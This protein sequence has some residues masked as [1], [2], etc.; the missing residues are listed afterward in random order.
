MEFVIHTH[1]SQITVREKL[2]SGTAT[3]FDETLYKYVK[4][5]MENSSDG[6]GLPDFKKIRNGWLQVDGY[7]T[8][9]PNQD[10]VSFQEFMSKFTELVKVWNKGNDVQCLTN[11]VTDNSKSSCG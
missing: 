2:T 10:M 7:Y 4:A 11:G 5:T 8:I 9:D 6:N 1:P 3:I